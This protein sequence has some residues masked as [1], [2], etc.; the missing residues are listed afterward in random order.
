MPPPAET[1]GDAMRWYGRAAEAG[2]AE[3]QFYLGYIH[4]RALHGANSV[5]EALAWYRL[6]A[7]QGEVRAQF[8]LG[9]LFDTDP[10]LP[11]DPERAERWVRSRRG[12]GPCG[13]ALQPRA[14]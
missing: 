2:D 6:A 12:A 14:G 8:R 9:L 4:D 11:R 10:R 3:A 1:Y 7:A 13:G 5:S